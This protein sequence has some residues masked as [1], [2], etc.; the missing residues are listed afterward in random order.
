VEISEIVIDQA[1]IF[2]SDCRRRGSHLRIQ[3]LWPGL[4]GFAKRI[5][6]NPMNT[7]II[8]VLVVAITAALGIQPA[9][10]GAIHSFVIT[11][12]SS[13]SLTVTYDGSPLTVT[14]HGSE[15]WTFLLPAGFLS[16]DV[17]GLVQWTEPENSNLANQVSF[18]SEITRGGFVVSEQSILNQFPITANATSV[19]VGT[20]GGVAVFATFNDNAAGSETAP[21]IG[22][23]L[24]LLFLAL[25]A[26]FGA[27]RLRSCQSTVPTASSAGPRVPPGILFIGETCYLHNRAAHHY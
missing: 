19:E 15:S 18:G 11:E 1:A 22:S 20:D 24:G 10:A 8:L 6:D 4:V 7:K 9:S 5:R 3:G 27:S 21:D 13:T 23:T 2:C 12:V 26:V 25:T 16:N 17:G 14:F